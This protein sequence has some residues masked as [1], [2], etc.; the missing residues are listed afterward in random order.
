[1]AKFTYLVTVEVP[2]ESTMVQENQ[3]EDTETP[4]SPRE[5]ADQ[6]MAERIYFEEEYGFP[7][8]VDYEVA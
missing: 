7:Y 5:M 3:Y 2:D 4:H 1:M 6:V 8:T